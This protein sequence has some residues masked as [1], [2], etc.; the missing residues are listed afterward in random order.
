M[1]HKI[2]FHQQTACGAPV[3]WSKYTT[4]IHFLDPGHEVV[5]KLCM[6]EGGVGSIYGKYHL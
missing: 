4:G 1:H 2:D 5:S 6:T 3:H